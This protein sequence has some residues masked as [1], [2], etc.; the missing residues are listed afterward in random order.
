MDDPKPFIQI[1]L[2]LAALMICFFVSCT[3]QPEPVSGMAYIEGGE[4]IIGADNTQPNEAPAF[5]TDVESFYLDVHPVTVAEF[6][7][8]IEETGYKTDAETFG[9]SAVLDFSTGEWILAEGATWEFPLGDGTPAND[10]HPV[11]HVSWNDANAYAEWAG[12]RL[13]N[14]V[15]WEYAAKNGE[16]SGQLY[17]WGNKLVVDGDY[18]ANIWQGQFPVKNTADDGFL[19]T[20]PVGEFGETEAGLTDMGGN[21]WEWTSDTYA[22]YE[23]NPA[24]FQVHED[25]KVIRG[26][27]FLCHRNVCYSY[28]VSARQNNSRESSAFHLGFRTAKDMK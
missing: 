2:A 15:E 26:G 6:R 18:M 20:S 12:R 22:L 23:G 11:T 13:P 14:E 17:S 1:C 7:S 27:S 10:D 5:K 9:D 24:P 28:R 16:N 4:I 19:Y 3:H 8:F 21:V 25:L